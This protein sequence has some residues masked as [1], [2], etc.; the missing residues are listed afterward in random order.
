V[1]VRTRESAGGERINRNDTRARQT[2]RCG[3]EQPRLAADYGGDT[4]ACVARGAIGCGE[5]QDKRIRVGESFV[6][7]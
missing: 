7:G 6:D 2:A 3:V 4:M 5:F 1:A